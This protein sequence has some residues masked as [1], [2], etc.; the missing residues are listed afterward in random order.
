MCP[1]RTVPDVSL[2]LIRGL[3][4][5]CCLFLSFLAQD[6][7]AKHSC[8]K[9][10]NQSSKQKLW[11]RRGGGLMFL[12]V[13]FITDLKLQQCTYKSVDKSHTTLCKIVSF[14][15]GWTG[16]IKNGQ[17]ASAARQCPCIGCPLLSCM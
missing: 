17:S 15:A 2:Y 10:K 11:G 13:Y 4:L 8:Q 1:T 9:V 16:R 7:G 12:N 5:V 14:E 6:A 3:P